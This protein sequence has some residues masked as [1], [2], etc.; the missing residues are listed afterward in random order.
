MTAFLLMVQMKC[1]VYMLS[2]ESSAHDSQ[3]GMCIHTLGAIMCTSNTGQMSRW[4][5]IWTGRYTEG[6]SLRG[7]ED[8]AS[9]WPHR[10]VLKKPED[11]LYPAPFFLPSLLLPSLWPLSRQ[12][13]TLMALFSSL[14]TPLLSLYCRITSSSSVGNIQECWIWRAQRDV[15]GDSQTQPSQTETNLTLAL[16]QQKEKLWVGGVVTV[17]TNGLWVTFFNKSTCFIGVIGYLLLL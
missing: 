8:M 6:Y 15:L 10:R 1:L 11:N 9:S 16:N 12:P 3:M 14:S 17:A 4:T 13:I 2:C 5:L 7:P